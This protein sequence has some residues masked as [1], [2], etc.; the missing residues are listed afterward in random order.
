MP[1]TMRTPATPISFTLRPSI[2]ARLVVLLLGLGLG[3]ERM[4][5]AAAAAVNTVNTVNAVG[6]SSE[7]AV[8]VPETV[9]FDPQKLA[10]GSARG[11][12][13][14]SWFKELEFDPMVP[15]PLRWDQR[16]DQAFAGVVKIL[17]TVLFYE[18]LARSEQFV[19]TNHVEH[20]VRLRGDSG[21]FQRLDRRDDQQAESLTDEQVALLKA[22]GRLLTDKTGSAQRAAR[23]TAKPVEVVSVIVDVGTLYVLVPETGRFVKQLPLRGLLSSRP[24]EHLTRQQ[25]DALGTEGRLRTDE[26]ANRNGAIPQAVVGSPWVQTRRVAGAPVVVL[27]LGAGAVFFT[28]YMRFFNLWGFSHAI[29]AVRGRFDNPLDDGEVSHFQALS[30][31]L[32][33]TIGLGNIA[34]VTIAM[35]TGGPGAFFWM[36]VFGF[37]GMSSKF[38]ECTLGQKYRLVRP[39]GTVSGGPMQYLQSGLAEY[40]LPK[41][42]LVL[43]LAFSVMCIC[44]SLGGGNMFQANQSGGLLLATWQSA[45][46]AQLIEL[47]R[48]IK[49][50]SA[51]QLAKLEQQHR[52]LHDSMQQFEQRFRVIYGIGLAGLVGIVIVGGIKRIGAAAE[53]LVPSMC[54]IY[55]LACLWVIGLNASRIPSLVSQILSEAFSGAAVG[56]GLLGVMVTGVRR[57][58]FSNEAGV[59]SAAIAHSAARTS[60]PIRE[61]AVALLEPFVDTVVVCSMTALVILLTG[62]W[63]NEDWIIGQHAEGASLT[64]L[65]FRDG[66]GDWFTYVLAV[67]VFLFAYSTIISWSYYGERCWERLFGARSIIVFKVLYLL[68]VVLGAIMPMSSVLDFSD[69]MILCMAFPNII[70]CVLLAPGVRRDLFD[71]WRRYKAGEFPIHGEG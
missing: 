40:G 10:D 22:R 17:A 66:V 45:D 13:A 5:A 65:A 23:I 34:G 27:W 41:L 33:A 3:F 24:E 59:G 32:S 70:G 1:A 8:A 18:P 44:G 9:P 2:L 6:E 14:K 38:V 58:A 57:A 29:Q 46:Q 50:A 68:C 16:V 52:T 71:Y 26:A 62:A 43:S 36:T 51:D 19:E 28:I 67:A 12:I 54:A 42:G 63:N 25:V 48:E 11:A 55:I 15:G 49:N 69:M 60:E 4:S 31:A 7:G 61:G 39:D 56:G 37:L 35:T 64:A 47:Q 20:Y 21:P 53:W 30:S